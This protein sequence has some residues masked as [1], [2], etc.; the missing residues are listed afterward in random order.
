VIAGGGVRA[1][2]E[3]AGIR[4]ILAKSLGTTNP[5][6]MAKATVNGL[7]SLR[8]PEDVARAR[9]ITVSQVLPVRLDSPPAEPAAAEA[10]VPVGAEPAAPVE[11]AAALVE[12]PAAPTAEERAAV[13]EP[14]P[15]S[16]EEPEPAA[17]EAPAD[18]SAAE[19]KPKRRRLR[20]KDS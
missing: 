8:R 6:N 12:E 4:D 2:L 10:E 16:A 9:G 14:E 13:A 17:E 1:V 18:A 5:I 11:E 15:P 19:E 3:L 7:K 20:R